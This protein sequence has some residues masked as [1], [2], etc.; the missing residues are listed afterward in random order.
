MAATTTFAD[1]FRPCEKKHAH[2]YDIA[3]IFAGSL[4]LAVSAQIAVP[5]PFSPVP[6][7]GQTF[8][9]LFLGFLL[10][11][12][13]AVFSVLL[14]LGQGLAGMPVFAA[15]PKAGLPVLLGPSG[16][17]IIGF[18]PAAFLTGLLAQFG[19]DR[20]IWTTVLAMSLGNI[21]IYTFGLLWLTLLTGFS[22]NTL[23]FGLYPFIPGDILKIALAAVM[24]P[25]GWKLLQKFNVYK[26]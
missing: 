11:P 15:V 14:Y 22:Y 12:K 3:L 6:V 1:V 9:V 4:L 5:L 7:T 26:S 8:A 20:R 24:L 21:V 13:R 23:S 16:G 18:V 10:G 2:I 17:Y 19:W 25:G